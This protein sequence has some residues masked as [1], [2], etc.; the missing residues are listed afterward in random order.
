MAMGSCQK[1]EKPAAPIVIVQADQ[2]LTIENAYGAFQ[3]D[4]LGSLEAGKWA[5]F[6][7]VDSNPLTTNP[8]ALKDI[9]VEQVW[10]AGRQIH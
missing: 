5:D 4:R 7:V 8:D 3:D 10:V 6:I 9:K 2:I 1:S